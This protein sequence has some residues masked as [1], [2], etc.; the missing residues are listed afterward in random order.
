MVNGETG[1]IS[2][3]APFSVWKQ[4]LLGILCVLFLFTLITSGGLMLIPWGCLAAVWA[5]YAYAK[6]W[7]KKPKD[8][9]KEP[10]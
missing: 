6:G 3:E 2:G 9:L 10:D 7:F 4:A 5:L 1:E 8:V